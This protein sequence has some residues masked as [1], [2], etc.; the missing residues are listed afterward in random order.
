MFD[1]QAPVEPTHLEQGDWQDDDDTPDITQDTPGVP[2]C[3][4]WQ[5]LVQPR[6]LVS[7]TA[8]GI[9][10]PKSA[11][12]NQYHFN[13]IGRVISLGHMAFRDRGGSGQFWAGLN[14]APVK[15]GDWIMYAKFGGIRVPW[16]GTK[17]LLLN[18]DEVLLVVPDPT[19]VEVKI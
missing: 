10:V 1:Q 12:E 3:P 4:L 19:D 11:R 16:R 14:E 18:D 9:I 13:S 8:G 6:K 15:P 5:I 17:L 2:F 7:R